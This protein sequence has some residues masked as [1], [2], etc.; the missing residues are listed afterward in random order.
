MMKVYWHAGLVLAAL[1]ALPL[2]SS[3]GES[4]T[5]QNW[6][7]WRGPDGNGVTHE[8]GLSRLWNEQEGLAWKSAIPEWGTSTPVI[9][10][11]AIFLTSHVADR[12]LV[13]VKIDKQQGAIQWTRQVGS[14]STPARSRCTN[15]VRTCGQQ[16]FHLSQNLA[17]PS[18]VTNGE[19]VVVHFGNGGLAA[20]DFDGNRLWHRN[21]QD[22]FGKYSIWWGHANSPVLHEDLVISVCMQDSCRD[23]SME[24]FPSY[25]VAHDAQTG[26]FRWKTT[27]MTYATGEHCDSYT[28]PV[29]WNHGQR[30]EMIV[31]GG[32]MVD[33]YDP[34]S[35]ER[36]WSMPELV[37]N[38]V[39]PSPVTGHD[40]V[41]AIQGMRESLVAVRTK[42]DGTRPPL[43]SRLVE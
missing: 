20:F 8:T 35:G 4:L 30:R 3:A 33:A 32:Q 16:K 38:R 43:D 18:P 36:L 1:A 22:D 10:Q 15:P 42:G 25:I 23:F 19:Q 9:W 26:E 2:M 41:F 11:D 29:F 27:R 37:G 14:A 17:S 39:I 24:P 7:Q 5:G 34:R 12:D 40:T 6:P 31:M 21:L 13:L 28:T